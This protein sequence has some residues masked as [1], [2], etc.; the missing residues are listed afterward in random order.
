[1]ETN[2]SRGETHSYV[3]IPKKAIRFGL[4]ALDTGSRKTKNTDGQRRLVALT[5]AMKEWTDMVSRESYI[6]VI[7]PTRIYIHPLNSPHTVRT[8][9]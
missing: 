8:E 1:M 5:G 2:R 7:L 3:Q 6:A 4:R 9:I